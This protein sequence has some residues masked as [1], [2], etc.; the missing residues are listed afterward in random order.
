[1]QQLKSQRRTASCLTA[2]PQNP[3]MQYSRTGLFEHARIRIS[4]QLEFYL[5]LPSPTNLRV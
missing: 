4:S 5:P 2:P 1:M 3:G